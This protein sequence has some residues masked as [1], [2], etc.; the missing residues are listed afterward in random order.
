[1]CRSYYIAAQPATNN[2][3]AIFK[4]LL[5]IILGMTTRLGSFVADI[6]LIDINEHSDQVQ[7]FRQHTVGCSNVLLIS[8]LENFCGPLKVSN[9]CR[10]PNDRKYYR[11]DI[12]QG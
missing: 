1:M 5:T 4:V 7:Y 10:H 3:V 2:D 9:W 8:K 11:R 6:K 12:L